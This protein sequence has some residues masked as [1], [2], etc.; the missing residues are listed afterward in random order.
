MTDTLDQNTPGNQNNSDATNA[1]GQNTHQRALKLV[2]FAWVRER[3]GHPED[4]IDNLPSDVTT[5]AHLIDWLAERGPEYQT[6]FAE[7][8]QIIKVAVDQKH[9]VLTTPI[10][11][12][13]EIAFFPPVTGG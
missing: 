13:R 2:Y 12:A 6:V 8:K 11:N 10:A 5:V 1:A 3:I 4:V 9:S 7:K